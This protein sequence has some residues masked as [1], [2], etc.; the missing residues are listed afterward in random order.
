MW[1][2]LALSHGIN[3]KKVQSSEAVSILQTECNN[4]LL[5]SKI[6]KC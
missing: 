4:I 3:T 6:V 5:F 2:R 1:N